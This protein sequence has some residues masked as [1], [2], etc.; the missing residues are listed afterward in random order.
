MMERIDVTVLGRDYSL[1]C[2]TEEKDI[3]LT[4]VRHA[5]QLMRRIKDS[6]KVSG[7]E[8]IAVMAALQL[9][10]ELLSLKAPDKGGEGGLALGEFKRRID[11][12]NAM[13][14]DAPALERST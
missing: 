4:A 10:S 5:D 7:N 13:L 14:D 3:L 11:L 6:G 8:R 1:A 9:A 12:M 2:I